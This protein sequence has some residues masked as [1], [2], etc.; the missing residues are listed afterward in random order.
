[1]AEH[2]VYVDRFEIRDGKLE[3]FERYA[4]GMAS[5]VEQE[6]PGA[7]SFNYYLNEEGSGGTAVFVFSNADALDAHLELAGSRFQEGYEMLSATEIE[8]LGS[9]SAGAVEL[10]KSFN[11]SIKR[12][13]A[14]FGR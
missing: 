13:V 10:A 5:F 2:V 9:R 4:N 11:A 14:G 12:K 6:E 7:L 3:D 8:L 1:M